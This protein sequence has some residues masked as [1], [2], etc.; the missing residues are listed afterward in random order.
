MVAYE[1]SVWLA[2]TPQCEEGRTS[3]FPST[4][5]ANESSIRWGCFFFCTKVQEMIARLGTT[6]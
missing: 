2:G 6:S 3:A 1:G 4:M 5:V